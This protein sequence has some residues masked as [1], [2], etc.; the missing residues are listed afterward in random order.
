MI[1]ATAAH[2]LDACH[3][4]SSLFCS[5]L[6]P[7]IAEV[8][9]RQSPPSFSV[10]CYL[11]PYRSLLPHNVI[12]PT[13]FWSYDRSYTPY[14]PLCALIVHLLSS[15][16]CRFS[17]LSENEWSLHCSGVPAILLRVWL[18]L[19]RTQGEA[20]GSVG[21]TALVLSHSTL[22]G[23]EPPPRLETSASTGVGV[24]HDVT[25]ARLLS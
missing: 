1:P 7:S 14:L 6:C 16:C 13:T 8:A 19:S 20:N 3:G 23:C 21:T 24:S 5:R 25:L 15:F 18:P 9:L 11:C 4:S 12:S 17:G 22:L 10:L 2:R